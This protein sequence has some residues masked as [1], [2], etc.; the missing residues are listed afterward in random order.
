MHQLRNF[1]MRLSIHYVLLSLLLLLRGISRDQQLFGVWIVAFVF[2]ILTVTVRRLLLSLTLPLII[3]TGGLFVFILDGFV[4]VLTAWL[5]RLNINN[6]W[7]ALLGVIVMSM[8]NIWIERALRALGWFRDTEPG[9]RNVMTRRS[10]SFLARLILL[11]L[12]LFGVAYSAAMAGQLFLLAATLTTHIPTVMGVACVAFVL[13]V[14]GIAWLV[15]EGLAVVRRARFALVTALVASAVVAVPA[16]LLIL[17]TEPPVPAAVPEPSAEGVYWELPTGSRIA[18]QALPATATTSDTGRESNPIVFLHDFGHAVLEAD[19]AFFRRFSDAGFDVYLYDQV[20][21]GRSGWLDEI[22]DYTVRR[23]VR[24]LEA[25]RRTIRADRL[26]LV[27]HAG[28]AELAARYMVTHPDRVESVVFYGPTPLWDDDQFAFEEVRTAASPVFALSRSDV[29][30][31]VAVAV[32]AY[33]PRTAQAY[34]P[35]ASVVTWS[36]QVVDLGRLVCLGSEGP[37][38]SPGLNLYAETVARTSANRAPDPRPALGLLP[39]PALL[40]RGT[41]DPVEETVVA[42]YATALP[43]LRT[44]LI[45]GAGSLPHLSQPDAVWEALLAFLE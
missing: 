15:A 19:V 20:G 11:A 16:A 28:G 5:T 13:I 17:A 27:G 45:E 34:L 10:P 36:D 22:G 40:I 21:S 3:Q 33:S 42:Q 32:A 39:I 18:Y 29:P 37:S 9:Q 1:V 41:C 38:R 2:T 4:L 23:H 24:D 31:R 26:I 12:L 8:A 14:S 7:W 6:F 44:T 30:P 43:L 25:I 35:Q